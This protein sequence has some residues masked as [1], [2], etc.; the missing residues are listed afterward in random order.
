MTEKIFRFRW[1][2]IVVMVLAFV[3]KTVQA[4]PTVT[5]ETP[6]LVNGYY[7][8]E[9]EKHLYWF[10]NEVNSGNTSICAVLTQN[11]AVNTGG[12]LKEDGSLISTNP[13]EDLIQWTPIGNSSHNYSGT[14]DGQGNTISGLYCD[15]ENDYVGLFG[16]IEKKSQNISKIQNVG[17]IDSYIKGNGYVGGVC[18]QNFGGI[19]ENCYNTGTVCGNLYIGGVCGYNIG[20]ATIKNCYNAGFVSG[21]EVGGVCGR[22]GYG[23]IIEKCYNTGVVSG[24]NEHSVNVG[25][26][27]GDNYYGTITNSYNTGQVSGIGNIAVNIGGV[28]GYKSYG[29]I[30]NCYNMGEIVYSENND[31]VGGV[32]GVAI[33]G[34]MANCYY[35]KDENKSQ[36]PGIGNPYS[37]TEDITEGK[38]ADEFAN[39]S[40]AWLLN[41]SMAEGTE[42]NPL[43]W[44]Q[45]LGNDGNKYPVLLPKDENTV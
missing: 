21:T 15:G 19:I 28:C 11:I 24:T 42:E 22:N 34:T 13:T 31:N 45:K 37:G 30:R 39:G 23:C 20:K 10:A 41:G 8:I 18:G 43:A 5:P 12:V 38:S 17:V 1:L 44:Y 33:Y 7:Q 36:Y 35:L 16:Y 4:E 2:I 40:V 32:C 9:N 25:G 3:P 29:T 26:V 14:F 27:C 6:N